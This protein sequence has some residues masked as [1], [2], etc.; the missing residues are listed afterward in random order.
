MQVRWDPG[1]DT[2]AEEDTEYSPWE[3]YSMDTELATLKAQLRSADPAVAAACET[4]CSACAELCTEV[5]PALPL[6]DACK[7]A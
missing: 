6:R 7:A 2:E 3:L 5:R 4:L 1:P